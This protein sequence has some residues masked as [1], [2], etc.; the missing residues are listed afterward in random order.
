MHKLIE[1]HNNDEIILEL[2]KV[3]KKIITYHFSSNA[4]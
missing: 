1:N 2:K 3:I 4:S